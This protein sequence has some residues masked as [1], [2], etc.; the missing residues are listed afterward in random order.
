MC[1]ISFVSTVRLSVGDVK[2]IVG[3]IL[4][5]LSVS[6]VITYADFDS[7]SLSFTFHL[8]VESNNYQMYGLCVCNRSNTISFVA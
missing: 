2:V 5:T 7:V 4:L 1:S 8:F 6:D 3:M